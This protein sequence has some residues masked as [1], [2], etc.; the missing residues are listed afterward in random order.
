[1]KRLVIHAPPLLVA[2]LARR[3]IDVVALHY[4]WFQPADPVRDR[5]RASESFDPRAKLDFRAAA[6]LRRLI[7][8]HRP[9]VVHAF[10]PKALAAAVLATLGLGR[11]PVIVSF[12]G[13][14]TPPSRL[15]P[16]NHLTFL[17]RRVR[18]HACESNAVAGGLVA[19][20]VPADCCHTIYNCVSQPDRLTAAARAEIRGRFGV[21]A[22]AFVV[23]T[24]AH[25]R[26]VKGTDLLLRAGLECRDL[27]DVHWLVIGEVADRRVERLARDPRWEGRLHMPGRVDGAGGIAGAFDIFAMPSRHEGLCRALLEAMAAGTCPVVSDAG[28]MKEM[29]RH[30][31]DGLVVP[32]ENVDALAAAIRALH[33]DRVQLADLG[34]SARLRM[35]DVCTPEAFADRVLALHARSAA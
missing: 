3:G 32:R 9:D 33:A 21:P 1:M 5:L 16:A 34:A 24:I 15:D 18:A 23:G 12:R 30:G 7:A 14:S 26:P 17:S 6:R 4:P 11:A 31:R 13:I 22:D 2:E 25:V 20:G 19:A 8:M 35:A 28:G 29:V 10:S 27:A